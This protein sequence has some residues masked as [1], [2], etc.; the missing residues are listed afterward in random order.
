MLSFSERLQKLN[1]T[2]LIGKR[3]N[4]LTS[5]KDWRV[6]LSRREAELLD[7]EAILSSTGFDL[8]MVK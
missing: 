1:T 4:Y 8:C 6:T 5:S 7:I 3:T 2:L